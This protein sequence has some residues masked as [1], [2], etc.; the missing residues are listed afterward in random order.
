MKN[1]DEKSRRKAVAIQIDLRD[2]LAVPEVLAVLKSRPHPNDWRARG[3]ET[4]ADWAC[5]MYQNAGDSSRALV[6]RYVKKIVK[7]VQQSS[8]EKGERE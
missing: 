5:W 2:W 6:H 3:G 7:E 1:Q 8:K 4:E